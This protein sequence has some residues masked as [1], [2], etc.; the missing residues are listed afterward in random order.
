MGLRGERRGKEAQRRN[1]LP[2]RAFLAERTL[3]RRRPE[4]GPG[5]GG[6]E[7]V[8]RALGPELR[9]QVVQGAPGG[10]ALG[11]DKFFLSRG[12]GRR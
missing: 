4:I 3:P 12:T 9:R 6:E 8:G 1:A 5:C 11:A 10:G 2:R 7:A